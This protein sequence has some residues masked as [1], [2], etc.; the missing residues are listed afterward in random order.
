MLADV[1]YN[2]LTSAII[3]SSIEVHRHLGPGLLESSY[4]ECLQYELSKRG[5]AFERQRSIPIVYKEITLAAGYRLDLIVENEIVVEVKSVDRLL[6]I[7][8]AQVL[9]YLRLIKA[10]VT[11]FGPVDPVPPFVTPLPPSSPPVAS[12][13]SAR[14]LRPLRP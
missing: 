2:H 13:L 7:H 8:D 10:L 5:L 3:D 6:S 11:P 4:S 14:C 12:V 1:P 9:T